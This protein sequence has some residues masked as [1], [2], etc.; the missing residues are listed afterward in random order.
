MLKKIFIAYWLQ[1]YEEEG[2]RLPS[3]LWAH[4]PWRLDRVDSERVALVGELSNATVPALSLPL[5]SYQ[6]L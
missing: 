2:I 6:S 3:F 1:I 5:F 4:T